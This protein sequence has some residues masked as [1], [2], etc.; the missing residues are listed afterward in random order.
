MGE[1]VNE[2]GLVIDR[3]GRAT[4][5]GTSQELEGLE[6]ECPFKLFLNCLQP[7]YMLLLDYHNEYT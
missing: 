3:A 4:L 5:V 6:V 1:T 7:I 2:A